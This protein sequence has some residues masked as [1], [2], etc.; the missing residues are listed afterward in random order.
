M[1]YYSEEN[2]AAERRIKAERYNARLDEERLVRQVAAV[3]RAEAR[4]ARREAEGKPTFRLP[5]TKKRG[6]RS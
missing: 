5:R 4:R 2:A 1:S 3:L 6:E